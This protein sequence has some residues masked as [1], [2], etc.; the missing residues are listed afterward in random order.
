MALGCSSS[1]LHLCVLHSLQSQRLS[2]Q[3]GGYQQISEPS[4]AGPGRSAV[5]TSRPLPPGV[6]SF[7]HIST[8]LQVLISSNGFNPGPSPLMLWLRMSRIRPMGAHPKPLGWTDT[9]PSISKRFWSSWHKMCSKRISLCAGPGNEPCLQRA[10][11]I[12]RGESIFTRPPLRPGL[13]SPVLG[14]TRCCSQRER[15]CRMQGAKGG[16]VWEAGPP[17]NWVCASRTYSPSGPRRHAHGAWRRPCVPSLSR[18][19]LAMTWPGGCHLWC[20]ERPHPGPSFCAA[21]G[22]S[23]AGRQT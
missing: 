8:G 20:S 1:K 22:R 11:V 12:I 14:Q 4:A 2:Q 9:P 21:G 6:S 18:V 15:R 16:G 19:G 13:S 10:L 23:P 17:L 5:R 3:H 7:I